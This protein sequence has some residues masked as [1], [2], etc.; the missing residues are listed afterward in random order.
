VQV[1]DVLVYGCTNG[2]VLGHLLTNGFRAWATGLHG[3]VDV[4]G[5][6]TSTGR[7]AIAS[8]TGE[9]IILD[10][11]S[12]LSQGRAKMFSGPGAEIGQSDTTLFIASADNSLYAFASDNAA[13]VWRKRTGNPL[14]QPPVYYNSRVYCDLGNAEPNTP[15]ATPTSAKSNV[16][17]IGGLTCLEAASG[18]VVWANPKVSGQLV[19]TRN[20]RLVAWN[21][22]ESTIYILQP[23]DGVIVEA[24]KLPGVIMLKSDAF[25]DGNLYAITNS[26][27]IAKL[28]PK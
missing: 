15:R 18:R 1:G 14:S 4:S 19:G 2:R 8:T 16:E 22:A 7:A 21:A 26:G 9:L 3:S 24:I 25:L 5:V 27:I 23:E 10:G 28:A 11:L 20:K 6:L 12:G 17:T 13:Q